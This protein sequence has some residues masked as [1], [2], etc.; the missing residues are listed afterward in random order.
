MNQTKQVQN[1]LLDIQR[2]TVKSFNSVNLQNLIFIILNDTYQVVKYDRSI[3]FSLQPNKTTILGISGQA[4]FNLQTELASRLKGAVESLPKQTVQRILTADDFSSCPENW[5]YI[6]S[7][8]PST[9]FWIPI[10]AGKEQLGLWLEKYEDPEAKK[11]FESYAP[12]FSEM[13]VPAYAV[14]WEKMSPRFSVHKLMSH[15]HLKNIG[16]L[17]LVVLGLLFLIPIRLRIVAPCEVIA[18]DSFVITAPLDGIIEKVVVEP[19]QEV[20]KDQTLFQYDKKIPTYKYQAILKEVEILQA[21]FNQAYALGTDDESEASK[22]ALLTYK[23]NRS[24]LDLAFAQEQLSLMTDQAPIQGLVSIDNPD[25]WRGRPV[26]TGE[27]IM[28]INDPFETRVKIWIPERDNISF[29]KEVPIY[30]FLN[31]IPTKTFEAKLLFITP[32]VKVVEG[33]IPSFEAEAEWLNTEEPPKLG[34]KGSAVMYGEKVSLFY[35]FLRKPIG[36]LR[37][38]IGT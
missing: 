27:K 26:K 12:L 18:K 17:A 24:K 14:A 1:T 21:E 38:F 13:L 4:N 3:L 35:Y 28:T 9:I 6:Q 23:L 30:V 16:I 7:L 32:E 29:A 34:L 11:I 31:S 2:L 33:E 37:K 20:K 5:D 15:L 10:T 25:A 22:L 19:G 36:V 8:R